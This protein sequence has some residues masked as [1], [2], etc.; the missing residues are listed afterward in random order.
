MLSFFIKE[1]LS[2]VTGN[3]FDEHLDNHSVLCHVTFQQIKFNSMVE[4][5][6]IQK[7]GTWRSLY[8]CFII[9]LRQFDVLCRYLQDYVNYDRKSYSTVIHKIS[10]ARPILKQVRLNCIQSTCGNVNRVTTDTTRVV[11][12]NNNKKNS[13][14]Y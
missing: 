6:R 7:C 12:S 14:G 10:Q 8:R 9:F 1:S 5:V 4:D 3:I 13:Q 11:I 2:L